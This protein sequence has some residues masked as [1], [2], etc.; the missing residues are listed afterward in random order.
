M[1]ESPSSKLGISYRSRL[2]DAFQWHQEELLPISRLLYVN[3]RRAN[4]SI[5]SQISG[6]PS[7]IPD[8]LLQ[9]LQNL[10]L[11]NLQKYY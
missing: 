3:V 2:L 6:T 8:V 1:D 4:N 5:M 11:G 7:N 9:R 10:S